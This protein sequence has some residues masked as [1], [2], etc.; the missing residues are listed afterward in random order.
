MRCFDENR[1]I[2]YEE[3][4]KLESR[5][6]NSL[7]LIDKMVDATHFLSSGEIVRLLVSQFGSKSEQV[8]AALDLAS[9]NAIDEC[10]EAYL[11]DFMEA[12]G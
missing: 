5:A 8:K 12:L 10:G 2:S 6:F 3:K 7:E 1:D 9:V 4:T 11:T